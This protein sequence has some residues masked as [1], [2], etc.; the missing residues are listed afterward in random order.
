MPARHLFFFIRTEDNARSIAEYP[1]TAY[2]LE[3]RGYTRCTYAT[4][5]ALW[6]A[7][8]MERGLRLLG[9]MLVNPYEV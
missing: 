6:R 4:Y 8:D 5:R 7:D 9:R 1:I 3:Q 2:K